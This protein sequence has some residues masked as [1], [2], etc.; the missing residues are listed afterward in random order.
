MF[1]INMAL[2]DP[3]LDYMSSFHLPTTPDPPS[4]PSQSCN[5]VYKLPK[6]QIEDL[7]NDKV[8]VHT[9]P[10]PLQPG[11]LTD[12]FLEEDD[13]PMDDVEVPSDQDELLAEPLVKG[14]RR[15]GDLCD[16]QL[17]VSIKEGDS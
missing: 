15:Q 14:A 2:I 7:D 9:F 8:S 17:D 10:A 12:E 13:Y 5:F 3:F 4:G 11:L 16:S 1:V 6:V